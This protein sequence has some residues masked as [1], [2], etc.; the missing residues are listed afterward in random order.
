[1]VNIFGALGLVISLI[2]TSNGIDIHLIQTSN[3][4]SFDFNTILISL[5]IVCGGVALRCMGYTSSRCRGGHLDS[6][7]KARIVLV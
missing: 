6:T 7:L 5:K 2:A 4:Q 1:V 3:A